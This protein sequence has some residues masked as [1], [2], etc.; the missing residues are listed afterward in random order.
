MKGE[1]QSVHLQKMMQQHK[2][3]PEY[4][5]ALPF[6]SIKKKNLKK[7]SQGDVLLLGLDF[8]DLVLLKEGKACAKLTVES[9]AESVK[10]RI[11]SL[12]EETEDTSN[13]KKYE[14]ILSTFTTLQIRKLEVGHK[15]EVPISEISETVLFSHHEKSFKGLLVTVDDEI[16]I[17][18]TEVLNE[19]R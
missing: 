7:I 5:L 1:T 19:K 10:L 9:V 16:A 11:S 15:V 17:E 18:I 2:R 12:V 4:E 8:L 3:Y 13:S 6:F 14:N